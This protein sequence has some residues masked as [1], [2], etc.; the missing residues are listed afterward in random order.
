MPKSTTRGTAKT[1][2]S[3]ATEARAA[4]F[5][6]SAL[7][8]IGETGRADFTV[9]EVVER[10]KT[11]L[12]SFYQHFAT[13]DDLLLALIGKI[14]AESTERWQD[15]TAD[16]TAPDALRWLID[17]MGAT[18]ESSTQD[19]INRGLTYSNDHLMETRPTDF[20]RLLK[21]IYA[22]F[23][24]IVRRGVTEGDFRSDL[25]IEPTAA[26]VMQ[27]ALGAL[28]LRSLSGE[29]TPAPVDGSAIYEFC[30]RSLIHP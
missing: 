12:R 29:L 25:D 4:G 17:R 21:P 3:T 6:R 7:A 16:M 15:E 9:L 13:K 18:A 1:P 10:S 27:N 14:M 26:I 28:R 30:V 5:M 19:S 23:S 8:I 24:D 20:A 22:L 11:S 2:G